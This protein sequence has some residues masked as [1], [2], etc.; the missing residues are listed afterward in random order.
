MAPGG[1]LPV[2]APLFD[3]RTGPLVQGQ[4]LRVAAQTHLL[5]LALHHIIADGWSVSLF[6]RELS[7]LY[8]AFNA[9]QPDPLPPLRIRY[10]DY[11]AWQRQHLQGEVLQR[12]QQYWVDHLR[13]APDCLT[14]PA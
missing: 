8:A 10:G 11:A 12:Q 14:L 9:G 6:I 4:L 13:G 7:T 3:L 1:D 2:F 5:R